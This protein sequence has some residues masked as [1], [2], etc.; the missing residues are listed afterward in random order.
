MP[1]MFRITAILAA[2]AL[3]AWGQDALPQIQGQDPFPVWG[4][5]SARAQHFAAQEEA[6]LQALAERDTAR[7]AA[8]Q[9]AQAAEPQPALKPAYRLP[10]PQVPPGCHVVYVTTDH[11][12]PL[13]KDGA[14]ATPPAVRGEERRIVCPRY[15]S[16]PRGGYP[17]VVV[18][19]TGGY[20]V[21]GPEGVQGGAYVYR[22]GFRLRLKYD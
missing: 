20:V 18:P 7:A 12:R 10:S 6:R 13:A 2:L 17:F 9:S 1:F 16:T 21:A 11:Q 22:P 4:D 14:F 3:P 15:G 8:A 5:T 19:G